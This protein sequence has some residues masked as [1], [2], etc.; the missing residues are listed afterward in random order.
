[1]TTQHADGT[2]T[3]RAPTG[4]APLLLTLTLAE[5][6]QGL[7]QTLRERHFPPERNVVPAHVSLFHALPG[8]EREL[9]Q[10]R[11][12]RLVKNGLAVRPPIRVEPP[13]P[14]GRGVGFRLHS[15]ALARLRAALAEDWA[16]W[17]TPQDRQPFRPHV[18]VQN[19]VEPAVARALLERLS[20]GFV[21][22]ETEGVAI[23]LWRYL[24]G[25][26]EALWTLELAEREGWAAVNVC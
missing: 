25:P 24:G 3:D 13:Y 23:R 14:M 1:M 10:K 21:P 6:A 26:W 7:F 15:P 9:I 8:E 2:V 22:F 16:P 12:D 19:K 5:P 20:A 17:L 4:R 18:T 11:L